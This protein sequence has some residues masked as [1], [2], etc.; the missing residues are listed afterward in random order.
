MD[1]TGRG[2]SLDIGCR[3]EISRKKAVLR[4]K[5]LQIVIVQQHSCENLEFGPRVFFNETL[6]Q[7]D[8]FC[9]GITVYKE[10]LLD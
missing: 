4:T 5:I 7:D 10:T 8:Y 1:V 3:A 9:F 6:C 2:R